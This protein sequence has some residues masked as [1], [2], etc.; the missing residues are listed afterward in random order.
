MEC[1]GGQAKWDN[2]LPVTSLG[3]RTTGYTIFRT[4][5]LT[6]LCWLGMK[7]QGVAM[8][9]AVVHGTHTL[10]GH[11]LSGGLLQR[12]LFRGI[13]RS[14]SKST[15]GAVAAA[16]RTFGAAHCA[17]TPGCRAAGQCFALIGVRKT[18]RKQGQDFCSGEKWGASKQRRF[19]TEQ[20]P[21]LLWSPAG[22]SHN[23]TRALRLSDRGCARGCTPHRGTHRRGGTPTRRDTDGPLRG[24]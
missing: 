14:C 13:P 23:T 22:A 20:T 7:H 5:Q 8:R 1:V 4:T 24:D 17:C 9:L 16:G 10:S 11:A 12:A 18:T 21:F 2:F 19:D 6:P 15:S 3:V